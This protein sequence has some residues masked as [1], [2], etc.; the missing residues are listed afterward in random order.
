TWTVTD[1]H[2]NVSTCI[3]TIVVTDNEQPV[4]TCPAD[5]AVN[6]DLGVCEATITVPAIA[7]ND[8]CAIATVVNNYNGTANASDVYPVGTTSV[9]WTVT[10]IHGNVSTCIQTIVVTDNEQPVITCPVNIAVNNDLGVCEATITVPAITATD[11]CAIA[12]VVNNYNGTANASDVYP[13]G[14]TSVTWTVTDIHGNVS[15]CIQT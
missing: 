4:I 5:I 14:T 9:T 1:I 7:A 10:D 3:Q 6:N 13:V 15:T 11:N 2:G 8:N 12:T